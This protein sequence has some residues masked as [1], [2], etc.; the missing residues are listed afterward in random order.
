M[1]SLLHAWA[2]VPL[3]L[4]AV[5]AGWG[6]L[7]ERASGLRVNDAL[8]IPLGLAAAIV[9]AGTI[10]AFAGIAKAA[11]LLVAAGA[12]A[13]LVSSWPGR[14]LLGWPMLA[15][16]G[17]VLAYG[18]PVVLSGQATF[19][20]FIRL[21]DTSTW[22]NIVDHVFAHGRSVSEP[23]S[24]YSLVFTGDVGRTYPVGAF[25]LPGIARWL[26]RVDVAWAFQPYLAC[27]AAA[28]ALCLDAILDAAVIA[29]RVRALLAFGGAQAALLYGYSLWGGDKELTAAFLLALGVALA[30][31]LLPRRP[32]RA[33][34]LLPL[35][36]AAGALI[37]TLGVG[38]AAFVVPALAFVA[39]SWLRGARRNGR[40]APA[41]A[42]LG[43]LAAVSAVFIVPVWIVIG[44]TLSSSGGGTTFETLFSSGQSAAVR[45]GN[46]LHPLSV[47]QLAGIWPVGDFRLTAP[48][49]AT[50]IFVGIVILAAAGALIVTL[51]ARESALAA[52]LAVALGGCAII[53]LAGGTPW[54]VGK[55]LAISSP[56]L[57][58][59]ALAGAGLLWSRWSRRRAHAIGG[60]ALAAV[61]LGGVVWSNALGYGDATLAPR[62]PLAELEHI[63]G[64]VGG[65]GPTFV[66]AYEI[67]ADRHFL[68]AGAPVEPA[69]YRTA[70]LPLRDGAILT[71]S[72][73]ADLDSFPLAVIEEYPSIVTPR[74]PAESRPPS[75]YLLAWQGR[76]YELWQRPLESTQTVLEHVSLGESST[77][78]YCG[79]AQNRQSEPLCSAN[80]AATP[81]CATIRALAARATRE[82]ASIAAYERPEPIVARGDQT[83]WPG[84]WFHDPAGH[85]LTPTAAGV[86]VSHIK[87]VSDQLYEL[88][89][90]GSFTRGFTLSVDGRRVGRVENMLSAIDGYAQIADVHLGGGIH[91]FALSYPGPSLAPGSAENS[92]TTLSAI[93]LVPA[94]QPTSRLAMVAPSNAESLCNRSLDWIELVRSS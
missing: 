52:Y 21:D 34:E 32:T 2:L 23:A 15:A 80:P 35:A 70:T 29:R 31:A 14:R 55:A 40:L 79:Q 26:A 57:L 11:I 47:F 74:T 61:L 5:G 12:L 72:A 83:L 93:S 41:F 75:N 85:T 45:L 43:W 67:Y 3:A 37:Q 91:T 62:A 90:G 92:L 36:V 19:T 59:A 87:L 65:H 27:C 18:A 4:A 38:A 81:P 48:T 78:P 77:L 51:R 22:F 46:L 71:K 24:T 10:T 49:V 63:G 64:L 16:L 7:V 73:A 17:V 86:A 94:E 13:G 54:V 84:L 76:Y 66:N 68:R 88:W 82:R 39:V 30:A 69:E 56:A 25:M 9:L 53:F 33:R 60:I 28:V 44:D 89:L 8:L 1:L 6:A 20:G 50:A 42:S 58:T